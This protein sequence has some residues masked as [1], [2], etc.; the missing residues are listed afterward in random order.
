MDL[1]KKIIINNINTEYCGISYIIRWSEHYF[2]AADQENNS[3]KVIDI[4]QL[5][6]INEYIIGKN[7]REKG[8][9]CAKKIYHPK[10]GESLVTS[11]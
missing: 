4:D 6:I 5:K 11:D 7:I 10:Y 2:I 9:I 8:V 1:Y 3:F